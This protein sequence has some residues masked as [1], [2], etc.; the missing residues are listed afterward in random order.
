[1]NTLKTILT[2]VTLTAVTATGVFARDYA[3]LR[4]DKRVHNELLA[5]SIA[6]LINDNCADLKIRRLSLF[7]RVLSLR[8]Y[9]RGLGYTGSEV[10][11]YVND[12]AEQDRF[13]AIAE[14]WLASKGA[15]KGDPASYCTVGTTEI[16]KKSLVGSM[17]KAR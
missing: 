10:E 8:S 7:G 14:P 5:A 17:L 4:S 13:R 11:D 9:A 3:D 16:A 1:M 15:V 6:Y 12:D 2:V